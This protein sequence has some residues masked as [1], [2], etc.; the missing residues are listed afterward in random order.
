MQER[1][2]A[3]SRVSDCRLVGRGEGKR[4]TFWEEADASSKR[5][6]HLQLANL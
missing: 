2:F 1:R 4:A 6:S 5:A 3:D